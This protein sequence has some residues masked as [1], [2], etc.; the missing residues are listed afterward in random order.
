MSLKSKGEFIIEQNNS[1]KFRDYQRMIVY[2]DKV[3][4]WFKPSRI[5]LDSSK[6]IK[7][8]IAE[9]NIKDF[10]YNLWIHEKSKKD[11]SDLR[12]Y[13]IMRNKRTH[14]YI[15]E[16]PLSYKAK[17]CN[18]IIGTEVLFTENLQ[19]E[20]YDKIVILRNDAFDC[21]GYQINFMHLCVIRQYKNDYMIHGYFPKY[22]QLLERNN[23]IITG[24]LVI[25]SN[26]V[27]PYMLD[28]LTTQEGLFTSRFASFKVSDSDLVIG[29]IVRARN[30]IESKDDNFN[31]IMAVMAGRLARASKIK[32]AN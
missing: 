15:V 30:E 27:F 5:M 20:I 12:P 6:S 16:M 23:V 8:F 19:L 2:K 25:W 31:I 3:I 7:P 17:R 1:G 26:T 28:Y 18:A 24:G 10:T 11:L 22:M 29:Y 32:R 13:K 21:G 9:Y 4:G 14:N